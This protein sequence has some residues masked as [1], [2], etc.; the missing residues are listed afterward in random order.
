M[1]QRIEWAKKAESR[2]FPRFPSRTVSLLS[3]VIKR[4]FAISIASMSENE[5]QLSDSSEP[6]LNYA[7]LQDDVETVAELPLFLFL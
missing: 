5:S 7:R 3:T 4:S 1:N 2:L 6:F